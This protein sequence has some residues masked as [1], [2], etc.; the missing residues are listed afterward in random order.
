MQ[1]TSNLSDLKHELKQTKDRLFNLEI[2]SHTVEEQNKAL[3][4]KYANLVKSHE[5]QIGNLNLDLN[6]EREQFE[7]KLFALN[8]INQNEVEKMRKNWEIEKETLI[9]NFDSK[10]SIERTS[11]EEK[12]R[13]LELVF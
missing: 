4:E 9:N 5:K 8:Q 11:Y 7:K 2:D 1:K 12:I 13:S 3:N 10:I 6:R